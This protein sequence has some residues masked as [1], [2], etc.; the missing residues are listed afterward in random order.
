MCVCVCDWVGRREAL[1][2]RPLSVGGAQP[3]AL[4]A[5][6]SKGEREREREKMGGK[7]TCQHECVC[8]SVCVCMSEEKK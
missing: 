1:A 3:S 7:H 5:D 4:H 8:E 2:D 6:L